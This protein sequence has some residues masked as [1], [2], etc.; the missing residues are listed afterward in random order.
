MELTGKTKPKDYFE[1]TGRNNDTP[2][3]PVGIYKLYGTVENKTPNFS[4]ALYTGLE[5][6]T[7]ASINAHS[8]LKQ[9]LGNH[10]D[11]GGLHWVAWNAIKNEAVGH[12]SLDI[13]KS[14][15]KNFGRNVTAESFHNHVMNSTSYVEGENKGQIVRV[16][17][18]NGK[19]TVERN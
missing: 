1:Y 12:S 5:R 15:L 6:A 9:Y 7:V 16:V 11:A 19:F 4:M 2:E 3:D 10:A 13:T 17:M 18:K 14:Y 8:P